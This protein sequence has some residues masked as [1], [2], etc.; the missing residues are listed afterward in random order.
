MLKR[1]IQMPWIP[2]KWTSILIIQ[3]VMFNGF[4]KFL[5]VERIALCIRGSFPH[6]LQRQCPWC[7]IWSQW[8][9]L[10]MLSRR[11]MEPW[12]WQNY[13]RKTATEISFVMRVRSHHCCVCSGMGVPK[14][15]KKRQMLL[16]S[17]LPKG[18]T[19]SECI[20]SRPS[21]YSYRLWGHESPG[22]SIPI[23]ASSS[24]VSVLSQCPARCCSAWRTYKYSHYC[25]Y[26]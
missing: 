26:W 8:W 21:P 16:G 23:E 17:Q 5:Q 13:L 1:S 22:Q 2:G 6:L 18:C 4:W 19:F 25:M 12:V 14:G 10:V 11:Y 15:R 3:L 9:T 7:G 20:K 24:Y